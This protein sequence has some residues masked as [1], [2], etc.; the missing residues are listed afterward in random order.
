MADET[1]NPVCLCGDRKS[2]HRLGRKGCKALDC[3]CSA[4][5]VAELATGGIVT[6]L[7]PFPP[8]GC[9]IEQPSTSARL[10]EVER[11]L[12][13]VRAERDMVKA[14]LDAALLQSAAKVDAGQARV[15]ELEQ[16]LADAALKLTRQKS[17]AA[18]EIQRLGLLLKN[19]DERFTTLR[20]ELAAAPVE[21]YGYD[22]WLCEVCGSRYRPFHTHACGPLTPVRVS[23]TER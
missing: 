13:E 21:L 1:T 9:V 8:V 4:F 23:I 6:G 18:V 10:R 20:S 12:A 7:V 5:E 15:A 11:E 2:E 3:G 19:A 17:E 14:K 22:A 16:L